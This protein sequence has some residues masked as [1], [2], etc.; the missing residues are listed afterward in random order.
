MEYH[1]QNKSDH[2]IDTQNTLDESWG[3]Y[4]E[5]Q[6]LNLKGYMLYDSLCDILKKA[7]LQEC[8]VSRFLL[9]NGGDRGISVK[10]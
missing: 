1:S 9:E 7:T 5:W 8:K 6:K 10:E 4:A 3:N 2:T